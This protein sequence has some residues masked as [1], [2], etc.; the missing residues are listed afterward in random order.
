M[1]FKSSTGLIVSLA[2]ALALFGCAEEHTRMEVASMTR[3][4]QEG[5]KTATFGGG[6]FWC[7]QPPFD[8]V[9]GVASTTVGYSGG[10]DDTP[11]YEEV[12]SG[13][14]G[15]AEVIQVVYDPSKITYPQ[16]LDIFWRNIDPTA[17]DRQFAD[18]G[19]QYRTAIFYHD[20]EQKR[21]AEE[22][23]RRLE[24]SGKFD[25]PIATQIVQAATFYPAETYHQQYYLKN[26]THYESYKV[27]SGRAGY[28]KKTWLGQGG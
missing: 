14:T 1:V 22:S 11:T 4:N 6:C 19:T 8:G 16:L 2:W 27:G 13:V 5:F 15:H 12:C 24:E 21:L 25:K 23:K 17:V 26:P 7:M 9:E 10:H 20:D 28:L 3:S 18:V